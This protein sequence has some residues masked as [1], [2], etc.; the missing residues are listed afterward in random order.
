MLSSEVYLFFLPFFKV[1]LPLF[2]SGKTVH[3][4]VRYLSSCAFFLFVNIVIF[5]LNSIHIVDVLN[6]QS[7]YRFYPVFLKLCEHFLHGR[8]FMWF[9]HKPQTGLNNFEKVDLLRAYFLLPAVLL[10]KTLPAYRITEYCRSG[11]WLVVEHL[12]C[13]W[14]VAGLICG[15]VIP[16]PLGLFQ[17]NAPSGGGPEL[18]LRGTTLETKIILRVPPTK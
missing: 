11:Q 13:D 17:E 3:N 8:M 2:F 1:M 12:L 7:S 6:A 4:A 5:Y 16:K 9:G 14:E 10:W 15:R 18:F